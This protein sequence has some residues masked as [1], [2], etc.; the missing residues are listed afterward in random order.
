MTEEKKKYSFK[1]QE[2]SCADRV[3][4]TRSPVT[5]TF[6]DLSRWIVQNYVQQIFPGLTMKIPR[7]EDEVF[8]LETLRKPLEEG[9]DQTSCIFFVKD[10]NACAIRFA[11]P[12]SCQTFPLAHDGEKFYV[13]DNSCS[14]IGKGEVTKEV[15]QEQRG[16]A[17]QELRERSETLSALPGVYSIIMSDMMRQSAEM[18]KG[19]SPEDREKLEELM[20]KE[21]DESE[22]EKEE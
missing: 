20:S 11:R 12:I 3:C 18:M 17:E 19:M 21:S 2:Q 7:A 13:T 10:S 8:S 16:L 9:S 22:P 15:L 4:C 14:G 1:C 6:G 5:V